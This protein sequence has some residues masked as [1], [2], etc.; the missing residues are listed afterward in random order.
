MK[1]ANYGIALTW[2]GKRVVW[3]NRSNYFGDFAKVA[4]ERMARSINELSKLGQTVFDK[5]VNARAI[6]VYHGK[7]YTVVEKA[8]NGR[9]RVIKR[10][11]AG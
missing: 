9:L 7:E 8:G 2:K 10:T 6:K 11:H 4:A 5:N 3:G 1:A